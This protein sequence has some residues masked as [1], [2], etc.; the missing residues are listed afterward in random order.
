MSKDKW[1]VDRWHKTLYYHI[2]IFIIIIIHKVIEIIGLLPPP[3]DRQ[4]FEGVLFW[5]EVYIW[6]CL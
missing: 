2:I 3:T 1:C 6:I 4:W 5:Y